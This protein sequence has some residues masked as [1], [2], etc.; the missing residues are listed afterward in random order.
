MTDDETTYVSVWSG[1]DDEFVEMLAVLLESEGFVV[2]T[3]PADGG[4]RSVL[5]RPEDVD[6]V[7]VLMSKWDGEAGFKRR[8]I[9]PAD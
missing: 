6:R 8:D 5:V 3:P 4:R 1:P 7:R 2:A 9:E